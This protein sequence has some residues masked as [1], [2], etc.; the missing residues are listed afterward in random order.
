MAA[1]LLV[2]PRQCLS[3][4]TDPSTTRLLIGTSKDFPQ[5]PLQISPVSPIFKETKPRLAK[6]DVDALEQE[7]KRN[8]KPNAVTKRSFAEKL[9]VD[10]AR[11]NNWF[12]NRRAKAKQVKKEEAYEAQL[13]CGAQQSTSSASTHASFD[14]PRSITGSSINSQK[15]RKILDDEQTPAS[16]ERED[17]HPRQPLNSSSVQQNDTQRKNFACPFRKHNP[18]K[19]DIQRHRICALTSFTTIARLKE[20]LYRYHKAPPYCKRCWK[21]FETVEQREIH[22]TAPAVLI[23]EIVKG[24]PPEGV[25]P[26]QQQQLKTKAKAYPGQTEQERWKDIYRMLFPSC[27]VPS[28]YWEPIRE[29]TSPPPATTPIS[30]LQYNMRMRQQLLGLFNS[31]LEEVTQTQL[32]PT[33]AAVVE[34]LGL[35]RLL[36]DCLDQISNQDLEKPNTSDLEVANSA[37]AQ[38]VSYGIQGPVANFTESLKEITTT[39][40]PDH[41]PLATFHTNTINMILPDLGYAISHNFNPM[42]P[43]ESNGNAIIENEKVLSVPEGF[44]DGFEDS[45]PYLLSD[46]DKS[47]STQDGSSIA[48]SDALETNGCLLNAEYAIWD[49]PDWKSSLDYL[50]TDYIRPEEEE[51][52]YL[53]KLPQPE[54]EGDT[55]LYGTDFAHT[56]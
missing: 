37:F 18:E 7:F 10:L 27:T 8:P 43:P 3:P 56:N 9:H 34:K 15:K 12:Q 22:E 29:S 6:D 33:E 45:P 1:R 14:T 53:N 23:C 21:V 26:D 47:P 24:S 50:G 49:L 30:S 41:V 42:T 31:K 39:S 48:T 38:P 19:Y 25:R 5:S 40:T 4:I 17:K 52:L 11:V 44:R 13:A 16:D 35:V 46:E 32:Q 20:H 54:L 36:E 55:C 51:V 28:P 2:Q